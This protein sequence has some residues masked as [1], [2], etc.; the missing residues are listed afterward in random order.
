[1]NESTHELVR[2]H[3]IS[4]RINHMHK[5]LISKTGSQFLNLGQFVCKTVSVTGATHCCYS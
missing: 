2:R 3:D 1:M 4:T 5:L